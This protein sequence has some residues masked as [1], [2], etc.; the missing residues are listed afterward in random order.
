LAGAGQLADGLVALAFAV[1]L[2]QVMGQDGDDGNQQRQDGDQQRADDLDVVEEH[3][4]LQAKQVNGAAL[5]RPGA[6]FG[7]SRAQKK[8]EPRCA[9][10]HAAPAAYAGSGRVQRGVPKSCV[11]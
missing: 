5:E 9:G 8:P 2:A 4:R 3:G 6:A 11:Q 1:G 10:P 7:F